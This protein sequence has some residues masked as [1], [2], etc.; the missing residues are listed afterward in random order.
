MGVP[1]YR[2]QLTQT[3]RNTLIIIQWLGILTPTYGN[4]PI[5]YA[6]SQQGNNSLDTLDHR[7]STDIVWTF[8]LKQNTHSFQLHMG[9]SPE[10]II[11][12]ATNQPSTGT[13][14]TRRLISHPVHFRT[15]TLWNSKSTVRKNF[16]RPKI[17]GDYEHPTREWME[18]PGN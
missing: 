18:Q 6:L 7:D 13:T 8:F 10:K 2:N 12:W 9:H 15:T 11:S 14:G 4:G 1:K 17:R 3:Y 5:I 16:N